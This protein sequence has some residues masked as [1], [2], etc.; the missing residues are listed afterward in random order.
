V[1]QYTI[2]RINQINHPPPAEKKPAINQIIPMIP[3]TEAFAL[4]FA[5]IMSMPL[6][7]GHLIGDMLFSF[8][9]LGLPPNGLRYLRVGGRGQGLGAGKTRSEENARKRRRIPH[10]RCT[11]CSAAVHFT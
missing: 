4:S 2:A 11:P 5:D 9:F 6:Q 3:E 10:V 7:F 8:S 1:F